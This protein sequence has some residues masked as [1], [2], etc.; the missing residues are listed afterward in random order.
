V[1]GAVLWLPVGLLVDVVAVV[2]TQR[3][4]FEVVGVVLFIGALTQLILAVILHLVPQLRGSDAV[5]RDALRARS[6]RFAVPRAVLL[7]VGVAAVALGL[8]VGAVSDLS[9][10]AVVRWGWVA[11]AIGILAH[12]AP[13]LRPVDVTRGAA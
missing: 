7:N 10:A 5:T 8:A 6:G 11:I 3:Q 4:L 9:T 12:L 2:T 1:A 13:V